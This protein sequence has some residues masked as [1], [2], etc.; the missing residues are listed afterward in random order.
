MDNTADLHDSD[1]TGDWSRLLKQKYKRELGEISRE[2]P[3]KRSLYI[4][5][6]DIEKFGKVGIGL[7]DE[8]LEN[9]GKVIEDVLE[10]IKANQL[11]RTKDGNEPKGINIRFTNLPKKTA[12]R[13]IRSEDINTFV[14]VEG[15]LR[16]TTEVRPRIVEAVFRCPAGHFTKKEQKYG[17]FIDPDGCA[18]D[19]CTF[20]KIELIPKRS[21]FVDSQK[22]RIQESPEGLRGGEQPQ[23]LDVDVTDDLSGKVSPGDRIIINGILRSMQRVIKGEKS[24]VFDIFLEC[25]SIEVAE[26]EFEEVEI[27]EKAEDEIRRLSQDPMIYRM[28]THSIAPTIYGGEDVKQAIALQLFGGISKEMPDGSRLRGDIHVLLIGDPGIAKSQLL[29]YVVKLSPRAIYTSGQSSTAAGLTATAVKDEFGE[30]RWTLEAG[31]L[32]LADMGVA[33]VDEMDKMEKG[34]RSALHEAM[35]QQS[36]SVAK[37]GITATLKS[38]CALLG[39]ANPKYGRFDMFGDISDQINMPPSLL[40][41]FDLIFIMT[42]QPE[43]KRDLAI[44]EH[45]LKAHSTGE[46]IAQHKKTPIP[47]VTDEYIAQQL[48]PVM[49]DIDPALFRK[50][51]AY[52]KRSC[53]PML[54]AEAKEAIVNYYLKLRGIAEPNKPVPVTARQLEALVRLAEASARIRLSDTIDHSDAERVIHIVDACLRQIAYDAKTGTFDIDKV[55]T[56]ISKE[57]RDIVRV[58]KDAIRDIGGEGRRA[59]IDQVIDAVSSKGFARDKVREGIDMLLRHGEAME[60][61]SGIIQLI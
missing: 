59:G 34:D 48:K 32:V 39:A 38:R 27:D 22:L 12:I 45:I 60:P 46:L 15:I 2:Y 55:V 17:K 31:A 26:K 1:K 20:K 44:A 50:Y 61:K 29:R 4:D 8:L 52:A 57:K 43:Q 41:R 25:N 47:G 7:A 5:Y 28:I 53:F 21:K 36:I 18:T 42:D 30:G 56:G 16:K 13:N 24:T 14:S 23:T 51:V 10:A 19:G 9:P 3:H 37:A 33:A 6:R 58:I 35:E 49:P 11:I 40:S 54:S